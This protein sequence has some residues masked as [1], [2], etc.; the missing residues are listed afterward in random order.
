MCLKH[1]AGERT[2]ALIIDQLEPLRWTSA[3]SNEAFSICQ[4]MIREAMQLGGNLLVVIGCRTFD[5]EHDPQIRKWEREQIFSRK[6]AVSPLPEAAIREV[7]DH[8]GV[9]FNSLAPREK[10]LLSNVQNLTMWAEIADSGETP[11]FS[12]V[13]ELSRQ[14]WRSRWDEIARRGVPA[15]EVEACSL[16]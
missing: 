16:R 15:A 4:E 6:V 7:V 5:L 12:T 2:S 8:R 3:H 14:F 13:T 10:Q 11:R 9:P 1:L